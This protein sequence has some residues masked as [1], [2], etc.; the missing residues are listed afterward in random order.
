MGDRLCRAFFLGR[1]MGLLGGLPPAVDGLG[2][3]RGS[4]SRLSK[5]PVGGPLG[6]AHWPP[7]RWGAFIDGRM[8]LIVWHWQ[9]NNTVQQDLHM[10]EKEELY[11]MPP[12]AVSCSGACAQIQSGNKA[13]TST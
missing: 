1:P 11:T 10:Y 8:I 9:V 4:G 5:V 13:R 7:D 12:F 2:A 6:P 3:H